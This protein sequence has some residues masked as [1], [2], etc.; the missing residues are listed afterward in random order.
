MERRRE[1]R[2]AKPFSPLGAPD[3]ESL[4]RFRPA[5]ILN[6]ASVARRPATAD[7]GGPGRED[8]V[9]LPVSVSLRP[10]ARRL[11][12]TRLYYIFIRTKTTASPQRAT[13]RLNK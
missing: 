9:F 2:R 5:S 10:P 13:V 4:L 8:I 1:E 12:S 3:R 7:D 11:L 6:N